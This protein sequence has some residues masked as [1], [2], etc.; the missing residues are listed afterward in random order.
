M[1]IQ[2]VLRQVGEQRG[3]KPDAAETMLAQAVARSL[4]H[5]VGT[6]AVNHFPEKRLEFTCRRGRPRRLPFA[7]AERIFN[8]RNQPAGMPGR[9][10]Y[11]PQQKSR[12]RLAVGA[13]DAMK[14]QAAGRE[15]VKIFTE[16][17][18]G[19]IGVADPDRADSGQCQ[20]PGMHNQHRAAPDGLF[21]VIVPVAIRAGDRHKSESGSDGAGIVGHADKRGNRRPAGI[22]EQAVFVE[23]PVQ[24]DFSRIRRPHRDHLSGRR[25]NNGS[26]FPALR[27]VGRRVPSRAV[28][29]H[30]KCRDDA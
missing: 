19:K 15:A 21:D 24:I 8:G 16:Q 26:F 25:Q 5:R 23:Q 3:L 22:G 9:L 27:E 20:G 29:G 30:M 7:G 13:G 1:I 10:E 14:P 2:V 12:S 6:T 11:A 17:S 28:S 18:I 4:H